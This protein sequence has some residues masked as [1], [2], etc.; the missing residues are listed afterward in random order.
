[1]KHTYI[2]EGM[3]CSGCK[4]SVEKSIASLEEVSCNC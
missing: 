1:M 2:V 3:T 4:A